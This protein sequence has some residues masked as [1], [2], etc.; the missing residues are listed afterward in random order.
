MWI[1]LALAASASDTPASDTP[2]PAPQASPA[3]P[4]PP[5]QADREWEVLKAEP[6]LR[7]A[8]RAAGEKL[9]S[10]KISL[11]GGDIDGQ[12]LI[13]LSEKAPDEPFTRVVREELRKPLDLEDFLYFLDDVLVA[14]EA[15]RRGE[16]FW[17][18]TGR[19]RSAG[20]L[21]HPDDVF[22][23][24]KPRNYPDKP[25]LAV[26][27]PPPQSSFPEAKD[28]ELLGP[29]WTMRYKSPESR[30]E[31]FATLA[32]KRPESTFSSRIAAL[33]YQLE[34][35]GT[36]VYL[37]SFLRYRQRGYLMWGAHLLRSCS[38]ETC[39]RNAVTKLKAA[40][41]SWAHVKIGWSHPQGWRATRE[42]ARQM[43]DAFDVVFATERGARYSN[44][45]D[46]TAVDFSATA[47]PR[48]LELVAPNGEKRTFDLSGPDQPRDLSLTPE[49][50]DW[51]EVNFQLRKLN[52][53]H[54]HWDDAAET[55]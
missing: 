52:S 19:A 8:F 51:I 9:G 44:H 29:N 10:W 5:I 18:P 24:D 11:G 15:G 13:D 12:V 2:A 6:D 20:I 30:E 49:V 40:N 16:P 39:V 31:M 25:E 48:T 45:Y 3:P 1:L 50:I 26:D 38:T 34:Q 42:A 46:G 23:D 32:A 4:P 33:V 21:V 36:D 47:L 22:R 53:D 14:G 28:G 27:K 7:K 54:P 35:Q 41:S 17:V 37:S 43:A 55:G